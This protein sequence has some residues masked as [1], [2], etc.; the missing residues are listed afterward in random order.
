MGTIPENQNRLRSI[1]ALNYSGIDNQNKTFEAQK[2]R[3]NQSFAADQLI[4]NRSMVQQGRVDGKLM[5][6]KKRS[7]IKNRENVS[8]NS[9]FTNLNIIIEDRWSK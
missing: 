2:G 7:N 4:A 8:D 6:E 9:Y 1:S 5:S 3:M